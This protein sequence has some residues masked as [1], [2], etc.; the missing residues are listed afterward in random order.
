MNI[1]T[2]ALLALSRF[3]VT[4]SLKKT[5]DTKCVKINF[6]RIEKNCSKR[7]IKF[8]KGWKK[9]NIPTQ[10][11]PPAPNDKLTTSSEM[12]VVFKLKINFCI[13]T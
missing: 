11:N 1:Q 8:N 2:T 10:N 9:N 6:K 7:P 12:A 4:W 13:H 3:L 5:R